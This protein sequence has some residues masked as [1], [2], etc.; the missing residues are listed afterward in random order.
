MASL[1][2]EIDPNK[3]LVTF[4]KTVWSAVKY[5]DIDNAKTLFFQQLFLNRARICKRFRV[6]G[7]DYKE[8]FSPSFVAW[9]AGMTKRV[10]VPARQATAAGGIDSLES[11]LEL[12]KRLQI[13]AQNK[14]R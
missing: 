5:C 9:P 14:I 4:I 2:L 3:L 12:L 11:M 6:Q 8:S 10:I 13:R 7:I 1:E